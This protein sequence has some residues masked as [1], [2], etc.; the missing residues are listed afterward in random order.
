M[1]RIDEQLEAINAT[2]DA[3]EALAAEASDNEEKDEIMDKV[4]DP[5]MNRNGHPPKKELKKLDSVTV[6]DLK[7]DIIDLLKE[8]DSNPDKHYFMIPELVDGIIANYIDLH[9]PTSPGDAAWIETA[10]DN[11]FD[12]AAKEGIFVRPNIKVHEDRREFSISIDYK[13][14]RLKED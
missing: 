13:V 3:K 5:M 2:Q 11:A 10:I 1:D 12:E 8:V 9:Q 6:M 4:F 7:Q 14:C